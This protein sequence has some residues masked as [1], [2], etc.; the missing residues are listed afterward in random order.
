MNNI[1]C[2]SLHLQEH[3]HLEEQRILHD[4]IMTI[5][6]LQRVLSLD[7]YK[8]KISWRRKVEDTYEIVLR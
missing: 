5:K 7:F 4:Y 8:S 6:D 2:N 1:Y 3:T